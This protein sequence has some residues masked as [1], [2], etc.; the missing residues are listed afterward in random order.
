VLGSVFDRQ[1][2]IFRS[3]VAACVISAL[4]LIWS[5]RFLPISDYPDWIFE[6]S[7]VSELIHGKAPASYSFKHYPVPYAATVAMLGLLDLVLPAEVSGKIVLSLCIV[8][9]TLSST[10]LLKSLRPDTKSPFLLLPPLFLLNTFF[11]W[12]ELNYLFGLS[13]F[14]LYC[15]YLFRRV[16]RS[17]PI[18]W[19][20]VFAASIA[21]LF[22]H[23]LPYA[24]AILVT[25]TFIFAESR[26]GLISPLLTSF[27]PSI[28][29]HDLVCDGAFV[30]GA[31]RRRLE[32][33]DLASICRSLDRG[34]LSLSG[35][36]S[37]AWNSSSRNEHLRSPQS[38]RGHS[39][40][41]GTSALCTMG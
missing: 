19:W 31:I 40:D 9:F 1:G 4:L 26:T 20:L 11:F 38:A 3:T 39:P 23:F 10:Y 16:Y 28:G 17:E 18:N 35:I 41:P 24:T 32:V 34:F 25:L 14:F 8:L 12:G 22:C 33:L 29:P 13:F 7:I 30:A 36:S 2:I 15:G 5:H 21:M 6:G 37:V 27:A